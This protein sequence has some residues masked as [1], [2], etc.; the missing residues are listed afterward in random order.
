MYILSQIFVC[1]ADLLY[2]I[3]MLKK[4]KKSLVCFLIISDIIFACH[5]M[6]LKA[7][8]GAGTIFVDALYLI[9]IYILEKKNLTKYNLLTTLIAMVV[10]VVLSILTWVGPISLLPMFAMLFALTGM[11]FTNVVFVKTG[12][13]IRNTL[14]VIY[15]FLI[16]SYFGAGLE[17]CLMASAVIGIFLNLKK[18][19]STVP[20]DQQ[21]NQ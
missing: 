14:N 8:T 11:I 20:N 4:E 15:M 6:F 2:V 21:I 16:T 12:S 9:I 1:L 19:K 7:W 5:Y 10:V 3:S 13:L 18:N 17:L